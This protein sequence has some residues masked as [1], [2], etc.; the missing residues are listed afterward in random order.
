VSAFALNMMRM[1]LELSKTN[2]VFEDL[3]TKFFEHFL[4]IAEAVHATGGASATG[5]WDEQDK[6]YY[7]VLRS[8]TKGDEVLR[9]RSVVGLTPL[10]ATEILLQDFAHP[11]S[12]FGERMVWFL[13]HR[14]DLA[15]L[16]SDW[17][18]PNKEG[19]RLMSL[20]RR[21]R[22]NCVLTR[23]LDEKE[24]LS[25]YGVRSLSKYHLDHPYSVR[26]GDETVTVQYTPGEGTT[27]IYGGNSNWRGPIWL[28]VNYLIID[29]LRKLY[30]YYGDEYQV[31]CP[32]GS[33]V[34]MS[35][36]E[37]AHELMRRLQRLFAREPSGRRA[38]LGECQ[39][40]WEDPNF[41]DRLLFYEHFD[42][43]TGRGL[44]AAHQTGWTGLI[45]LL[46]APDDQISL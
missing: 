35:L 25:D 27:R 28:P 11:A 7:D 5:L 6:F 16:V 46:F 40:Q 34:M 21:F 38:Y 44:G 31:E 12:E 20:L 9:I 43:D 30:R 13:R 18:K 1:A 24:F 45:A 32:T 2:P 26:Q 3:A 17:R 10:F 8:P 29:A 4:Y 42:G 14:P 37:V 22:L 23:M 36:E 41:R 39:R 19:Y 15:R 33:G